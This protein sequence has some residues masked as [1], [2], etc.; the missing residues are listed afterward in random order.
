MEA[1]QELKRHCVFCLTNENLSKEHVWSE[2][3][4][5]R[6]PLRQDARSPF[7]WLR[8]GEVV[9]ELPNVRLADI[10]IRRVCE[11]CNSGWMNRIEEAAIPILSDLIEGKP[12]TLNPAEMFVA[13]TWGFLKCLIVDLSLNGQQTLVV[14][15]VHA[16]FRVSRMPPPSALVAIACYGGNRFPLYGAAGRNGLT[17]TIDTGG[18]Y[19]VQIYTMVFGVGH[20]VFKVVGHHLPIPVDLKP[21]AADRSVAGRV[22]P[23]PDEAIRWPPKVMLDDTSLKEFGQRF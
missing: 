16:W 11:T 10:R 8:N 3:V 17:I 6:L 14:P 15:V 12:R 13:A 1:G 21:A 7:S 2:W 4:R 9:R 5:D 20:L 22:W 19:Q 23:E 18:S